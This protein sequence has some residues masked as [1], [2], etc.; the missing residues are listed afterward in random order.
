MDLGKYCET[1]LVLNL[2]AA[3]RCRDKKGGWIARKKAA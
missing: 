3:K 1:H 2:K